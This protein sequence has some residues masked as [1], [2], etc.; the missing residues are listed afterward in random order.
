M[1]LPRQIFVKRK[2]QPW[3]TRAARWTAGTSKAAGPASRASFYDRKTRKALLSLRD[4][5]FH[6]FFVMDDN[7]YT[8]GNAALITDDACRFVEKWVATCPFG[9]RSKRAFTPRR[10]VIFITVEAAGALVS[11]SLSEATKAPD[12]SFFSRNG[13]CH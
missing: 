12:F 1:R 10:C 4:P 6:Q 9:Y 13:S 5:D 11:K 7:E 3:A 2:R 8:N